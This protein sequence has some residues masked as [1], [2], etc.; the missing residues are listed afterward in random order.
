MV[1]ALS[2]VL[3]E[4]CHL[5]I[6]KFKGLPVFRAPSFKIICDKISGSGGGQPHFAVAGGTN[7][8]G[9]NAA[10]NQIKELLKK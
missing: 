9:F 7:T 1:M 3:L 2:T 6:S 10:T 5:E 4:G 8:S